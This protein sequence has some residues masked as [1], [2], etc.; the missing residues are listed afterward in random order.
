M[1]RGDGAGS[2][3]SASQDTFHNTFPHRVV[4]A[5]GFV[6]LTLQITYLCLQS[7]YSRLQFYNII[8]SLCDGI[9]RRQAVRKV[10]VVR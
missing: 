1:D 8:W 9:R 4:D 6:K 3:S 10:C 5:L 7:P 2:Q